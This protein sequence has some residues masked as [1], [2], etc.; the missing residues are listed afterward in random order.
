MKHVEKRGGACRSYICP[1]PSPWCQPSTDKTQ[2]FW[3]TCSQKQSTKQ[4][5][6]REGTD[7]ERGLG[8]CGPEDLLFTPLLQFA[9]VPFQAKESVHKTLFWE[10]FEFLAST[11]SIFTQ[12]LG[13]QAPKF[14]NFQLTSPQIGKFSVHK[15]PNLEIFSS[16]AP[17]FRGKYQ[18]ASPPL[19]KSRPHT[20]TWKKSWLP[21]GRKT[22]K[23]WLTLT[24]II[25]SW[26]TGSY[27]KV[28]PS[29]VLHHKKEA[30]KTLTG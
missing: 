13:S 1:M 25:S 18:F 14:W 8:M 21:P 2:V 9:R 17:L 27:C 19:W 22:W 15:P 29:D 26:D 23:T 20:P 30:P 7:L 12:I 4:R 28:P 6:T 24:I 11:A 16:Q 3:E 5:K 10:T